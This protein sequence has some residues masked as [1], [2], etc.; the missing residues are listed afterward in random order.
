M[1]DEVNEL[2]ALRKGSDKA[3][4]VIYKS[5]AGKL[6]NFVMTLSHGDRYT[7]EEIVQSTFIKLWEVREQIDIEKSV[8]SYLSVIAK[9]M[10]LNKFQR[11]TIEYLYQEYILREQ[12]SS[13]TTT[14]KE[15]DR[16]WL[17]DFVDELIEQLPPSR[18]KI[19][20]LSRKDDLSTKQ[21][22]EI[23]HISVSTVETQLSLATR[24]MRRELE[25]NYDKLFMISLLLLI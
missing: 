3:F 17:A 6:Y 25:K 19:F 14:E 22:A 5:Y 8:H 7:S 16:K 12:S 10:L 23:M 24:F 1:H 11:Q 15:I 2:I 18:K 21:I 20:I 9:N 4:E 13:D